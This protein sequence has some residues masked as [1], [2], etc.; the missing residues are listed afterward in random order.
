[1]VAEVLFHN[2]TIGK[3]MVYQGR[4]ETNLLQLFATSEN[5]D[6]FSII[7]VIIFKVSMVAEQKRIGSDFVCFL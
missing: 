6:W 4:H 7:S 2:S 3:L 1:M 5:S